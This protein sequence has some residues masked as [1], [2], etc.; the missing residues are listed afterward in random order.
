MPG[1][2]KKQWTAAK[3]A[4]ET[5]TGKKKPNAK[6]QN[7]FFKHAAGLEKLLGN[8]DA[9]WKKASD[10]KAIT[11]V[12]MVRFDENMLDVML[13][14]DQLAQPKIPADQV[15]TPLAGA[16]DARSTDWRMLPGMFAAQNLT[17]GAFAALPSAHIDQLLQR[18]KG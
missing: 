2:W 10:A 5:T 3:T 15:G 17:R 18:F 9:A 6:V 8:V 12:E 1:E 16:S 4:F 14:W 11:Q 7:T 13:T